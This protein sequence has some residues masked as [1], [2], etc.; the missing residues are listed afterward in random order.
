MGNLKYCERRQATK[1]AMHE[2]QCY[3]IHVRNEYVI[4]ID[5]K[6][7]CSTDACPWDGIAVRLVSEISCD[8][9]ALLFVGSIRPINVFLS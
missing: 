9:V 2:V 8:C 4:I 1:R 6:E 5:S 7:F 3:F